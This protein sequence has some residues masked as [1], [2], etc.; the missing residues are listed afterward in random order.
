MLYTIRNILCM[1]SSWYACVCTKDNTE[2]CDRIIENVAKFQGNTS[3]GSFLSG[4]EGTPS[5]FPIGSV[6][7]LL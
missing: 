1:K 5:P 2:V 7:Q 6:Q 3:E 4:C